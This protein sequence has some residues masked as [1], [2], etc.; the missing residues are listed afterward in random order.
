M[1]ADSLLASPAWF[2]LEFA[3]PHLLRV[4]R[5]DE[6]AYRRASFLDRRVL[7][8]NR[9]EA[10]CAVATAAAAASRLAP[11]ADYVFHIGHVGSTLISR[12]LGEWPGVFSLREPALLRAIASEPAPARDGLC[13][14]ATLALLSRTWRPAQRAVI[15]TTSFVSELAEAMLATDARSSAVILFSS[16]LAYLSGILGG[17]NSRTETR[18]LAPSRLAR[19][20]RGLAAQPIEPRSEGEWLAMSWLA[21][22]TTLGRTTARFEARVLWVDFDAFLAAPA[23]GLYRILRTLGHSAAPREIQALLASPLMSRYSKAPELAYDASLRHS[24]LQSA[25]RDYPGEIRR[26]LD[27]L[28][29]LAGSHPLVDQALAR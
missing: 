9:Q 27:W 15:K 17:P 28:T 22:M 19:L 6:E 3:D 21:E 4:V 20:R 24:V 18:S 29:R 16:P 8:A 2:P 14:Q 26:G 11:A 10:A 5:L 23:E 13:L 12:L 1:D 7:Q 25:Q